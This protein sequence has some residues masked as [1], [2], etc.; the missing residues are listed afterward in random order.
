[1]VVDRNRQ[2]ETG[3]EASHPSY[4]DARRRLGELLDG[5]REAEVPRKEAAD[6]P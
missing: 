3:M 5:N 1:M 2:T 4:E 6:G